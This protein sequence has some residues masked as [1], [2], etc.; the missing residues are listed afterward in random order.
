MIVYHGSVVSVET[1]QILNSQ[2]LLDFGAGFYTTTN[3]E[4]AVRW[5]QRVA[6]RRKMETRYLSKYEFDIE[7][8]IKE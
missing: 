8:A 3:R 5:S 1:P 7:R 4:Q 6:A 2:R